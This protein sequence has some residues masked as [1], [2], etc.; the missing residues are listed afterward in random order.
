MFQI[1]I[2]EGQ[3]TDLLHTFETFANVWYFPL[4][5]QVKAVIEKNHKADNEKISDWFTETVEDL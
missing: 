3:I 1:C 4:Q 2:S 5:D